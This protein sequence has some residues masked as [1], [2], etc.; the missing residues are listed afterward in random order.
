MKFNKMVEQKAQNNSTISLV[1][2]D[3]Q[4]KTPET[5]NIRW[6]KNTNNQRFIK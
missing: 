2:P 5:L 3:K 6:E 4:Y 1:F